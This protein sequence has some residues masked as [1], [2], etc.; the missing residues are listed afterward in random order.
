MARTPEQ[1]RGELGPLTASIDRAAH[2]VDQLLTLAR[3]DGMAALHPHRAPVRLDQVVRDVID[4]MRP[5]LQACDAK[6]QLELAP[7]EVTGLEFAIGALLRNLIDN[8]AKYGPHG[9]ALRVAVG[10]APARRRAFV[11]VEDA[12]PGIP[13]AERDRIFEP[14]YRIPGSAAD[15]C[16]IGLSIV[17]SALQMHQ[18]DVRLATSTL[19]GLL[20]R[21]EFDITNT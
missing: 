19:G 6:L 13:E 8:A 1:M 2:L 12:G 18:T 16:G 3:V 17:R 15:G 4:E 20:V 9:G 7:V 5:R 10:T 14:F 11:T 21:V